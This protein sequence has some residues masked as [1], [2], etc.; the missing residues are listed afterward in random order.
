MKIAIAGLGRMGAQIA[1]KLHENGYEVIAHNRS[2]SS[3][4]EMKTLG[5][6]P[7]YTKE[8]VI[9]NFGDE[10]VIIWLMIPS[11][12]VDQELE[13]WLKLVPKGSILIDGGNSDFRLT[14]KRAELVT[15]NGS[16]MMD[17]GTSG[18]IWGYQ[19]GFCMMAG[20]DQESFKIIEPVL[21]T[22]AKPTGAY[23]YFGNSGAG[24]FVKMT[25][26]AVEYGMMESLAEGYR[27]LKEGPYE[28]LDLASA[29]EVWQ[30]HSVI[31]SWLNELS[32][33]ALKKNPELD[34]IEGI[35]AESG[36]A[37]WALEVAK[38][39]SID[40]PAILAAFNV[41]L[42]SQKG[43]VNFATKLLAAMRNAFGGHKINQ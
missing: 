6:M 3:V 16:T 25:H 37:R 9:K 10:P 13:A 12:T 22:L 19:N 41:R 14:K 35:V 39:L 7:A 24:H 1:K 32:A 42:E 15:Q 40:T 23:H 21:M 5:M 20:G 28:N 38:S 31:T 18:G 11:D 30:H 43:K 27:L 2:S 4:D 17:V 34:G 36:E 29:G 8:E 33:D 26:N